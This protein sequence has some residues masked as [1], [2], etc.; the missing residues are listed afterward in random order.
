MPRTDRVMD[1][2]E[3]LRGR[4]TTTVSALAGELGVSRRTVLRDLATLRARGLPITGE[5][6]PSGGL[7]LEGARGVTA[8][9]L[10][11]AEVVSL[12]L[13]ARL[14]RAASDLPW[15]E[16]ARS[17]L[18]KLM[19]SLPRERTRE[20]RALCRRVI[21]GPPA[22]E[23]VRS[24]AGRAP[25]ELLRLFEEAFGR[26][27]GLGFHYADRVGQRTL[28]RVEPHGLLVQTPVWYLLARDADKGEPRMF[29]MDRISSPRLLGEIRFTP[30][31]RV[32]QAQLP[33]GPDWQPLQAS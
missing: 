23:R 4:D 27:A 20:L 13:A 16:G 9:H 8:V 33:A 25:P 22:S 31:A 30:D 29:R 19:A 10:G 3:L 28:R 26:G 11:V 7:R 14:S 12:W 2:V 15:G 18:A 5:P 1:L 17:G 24:G 21:V 6:G 32:I